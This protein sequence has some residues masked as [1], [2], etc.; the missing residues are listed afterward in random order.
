MRIEKRGQKGQREL[1]FLLTSILWLYDVE[2]CSEHIPD[3][4]VQWPE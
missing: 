4:W 3:C 2:S 1:D